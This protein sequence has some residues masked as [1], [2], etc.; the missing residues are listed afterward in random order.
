MIAALFDCDGTLYSAQ[1]GRGLMQSA[2]GHGRKGAVRFYY[3]S[4]LIPYLLR[5][6]KL[7]HEE[8]LARPI[9]AHLAGLIKG[10]DEQQGDAMFDWLTHDYLLPTG[11]PEIIARLRDH[12]AQGHAVLLVSAAFRPSVE[13]LARAFGVM[14]FVGTQVEVQNGYYT[15]RII[16]P[17]ITGNDKDRCTREFFASRNMEIDWPASYAYADSITDLG[18]FNLVGHPIAVYPDA[19]LHALA[20]AKNWEIMGTPRS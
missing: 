9:V 16:P 4:I 18:L 7:I 17:V 14:G 19:K 15:G 10:L 1:F 3:A 2:S 5:K 8:N 13:R 11:R 20:Q 12:Q 6:L